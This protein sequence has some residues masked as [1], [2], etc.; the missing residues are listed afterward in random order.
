[1]LLS[2]HLADLGLARALR[3]QRMRPR[4]GK[5]EGLVYAE[6]TTLAPL[7]PRLLPRRRPDASA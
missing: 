2:L 3:A 5:V 6:L 4:P 7:G 1:M